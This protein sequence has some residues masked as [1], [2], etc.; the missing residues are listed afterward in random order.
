[1]GAPAA[2]AAPG[3]RGEGSGAPNVVVTSPRDRL[4]ASTDAIVG[5]STGGL[6]FSSAATSFRDGGTKKR[7]PRQ[8][9]S[10]RLPQTPTAARVVFG[11]RS[12]AGTGDIPDARTIGQLCCSIARSVRYGGGAGKREA[13]RTLAA[14]AAPS[15]VTAS[16]GTGRCWV[17]SKTRRHI[18]RYGT[19]SSI[20]Y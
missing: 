8:G 2:L 1:M 17:L 3:G 12:N 14:E 18:G 11:E 15:A 13:T 20:I 19:N 10:L 16:H 7:A 4:P 9:R 6:S 5:R